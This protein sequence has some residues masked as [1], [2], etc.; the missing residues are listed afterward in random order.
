MSGQGLGRWLDREVVSRSLA[1]RPRR[2][3]AQGMAGLVL[4]LGSLLL[5]RIGATFAETQL[6]VGTSTTLPPR[7]EPTL[8]PPPQGVRQISEK[9]N[10]EETADMPLSLL[11][12]QVLEAVCEAQIDAERA[13]ALMPDLSKSHIRAACPKRLIPK[14]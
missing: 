11:A 14:S 5:G 12:E 13:L 7:A 9:T 10:P 2:W 4:L 6:S 1:Q 8:P 3:P